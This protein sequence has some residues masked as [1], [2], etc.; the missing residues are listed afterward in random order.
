MLCCT[1][2]DMIDSSETIFRAFEG[3][4]HGENGLD[5]NF[6]NRRLVMSLIRFYE[7]LRRN[8]E[9]RDATANTATGHHLLA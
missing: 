8:F 4:P 1:T 9:R 7:H 2:T 6:T 3:E 5:L